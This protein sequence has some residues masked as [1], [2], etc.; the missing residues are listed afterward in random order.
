MKNTGEDDRFYLV[1]ADSGMGKTTFMLNLY[2][3][4][5]RNRAQHDYEMKL[6]A[7]RYPSAYEDVKQLV[8]DKK[9]LNTILLLDAFDED[10][11]ASK[12]YKVRLDQ[13]M[14]LVKNF[15]E[16]IITSRT[17]FFPNEAATKGLLQIPK[18]NLLSPGFH[19][20]KVMYISPFSDEDIIKYVE[21]RFPS[22]TPKDQQDKER[23]IQIVDKSPKLM[24]RPMLL[25]NIDAFLN[26]PKKVYSTTY[27]IYDVLIEKWLWREAGRR[28]KQAQQFYDELK[29]FSKRLAIEI[30]NKWETEERLHITEEELIS[31]AQ[32]NNFDPDILSKL[33]MRSKSL[34]NRDAIGNLKFSHKSVLEFFLAVHA[35]N[36]PS[37]WQRLKL[38]EFDVIVTFLQERGILPEMTM[39]EGGTFQMAEGYSVTLSDYEIGTYSVTQILWQNIMGDNPSRFTGDLMRPVEC[40][41]WEDCQEFIQKLNEKTG[42]NFRL[43][44]EAEWEFAARGGNLSKGFEY[45]GS[46]NL[47]E[48]GWYGGNSGSKTHSVGQKA[49]NELGLYDMS[50]NV[51]EW[52]QDWYDKYPSGRHTNL[53]GAE[54]GVYRVLRGGSWHSLPRHC[55]VADRDYGTPLYRSRRNGFRLSRHIEQSP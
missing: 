6:F 45:A 26:D 50:G 37:F 36:H 14:D 43:P 24:V 38:K 8:E 48:V 17:Q 19:Q 30:Y 12:N 40:V 34:L 41:S 7:F 39:V 35:E 46:N 4:Y 25:A 31:F 5:V 10:G 33:E 32:L 22:G 3:E 27:E 29:R 18:N 15:R 42:L 16:V 1:L 23:A 44:T 52:C 13:W 53:Q 28:G 51:W 54:S 20:F 9:D 11:E 21:M 49:P 47:D 2:L 55:R